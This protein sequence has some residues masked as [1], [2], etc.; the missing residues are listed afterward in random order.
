MW[1]RFEYHIYTVNME[2]IGL[3]ED[4]N[5]LGAHA[6]VRPVAVALLKGLILGWGSGNR[7]ATLFADGN[8]KNHAP[9]VTGN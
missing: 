3:N 9:C 8:G 2:S 6:L 5:L 4:E 7:G 1:S